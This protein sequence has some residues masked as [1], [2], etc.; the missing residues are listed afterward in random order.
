AALGE[1]A[2]TVA[3]EIRNPLGGIR[4]FAALLARD[5]EEDDP[6]SRLVGRILR[7]T[8]DLDNV[9]TQ[10]LEYTR[11]L[12]PR[13]R[14]VPCGEVVASALNYIEAHPDIVIRSEVPPDLRMMADPDLMRQVILNIVLNAVQ[15]IAGAGEVTISTEAG[16]D[17]MAVVVNDTGCGM[18]P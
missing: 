18:T 3:H 8:Q 1:M 5:I 13:I 16:N 4:G 10:L 6:R 15:S 11:P 7:G 12:Q 2:A 17:F 9:V 14:P